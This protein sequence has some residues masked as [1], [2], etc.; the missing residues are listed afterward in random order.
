MMTDLTRN[1]LTGW[2][3]LPFLFQKITDVVFGGEGGA[4]DRGDVRYLPIVNTTHP[5]NSWD[6]EIYWIVLK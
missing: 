4:G 5:S 3:S 2:A 6:G 1:L